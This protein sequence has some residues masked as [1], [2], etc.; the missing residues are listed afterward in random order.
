[1]R[2]NDMSAVYLFY[3]VFLILKIRMAL[4]L[5]LIKNAIK[6]CLEQCTDGI[7]NNRAVGSPARSGSK[8]S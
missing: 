5:Q 3:K 2:N 4:K 6:D 8:R 7:D 1:M